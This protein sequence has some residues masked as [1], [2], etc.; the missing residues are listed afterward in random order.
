MTET[1]IE[2]IK[3]LDRKIKEL[4]KEINEIRSRIQKSQVTDEDKIRL[5]EISDTI[6]E[7]E[8]IIMI[9]TENE[10]GDNIEGKSVHNILG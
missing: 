9:I 3:Y 4:E 7:Y 10:D 2:I 6:N 8:K 1:K 5:V